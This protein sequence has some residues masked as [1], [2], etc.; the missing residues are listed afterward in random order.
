[1]AEDKTRGERVR[2]F[3]LEN[4]NDQMLFSEGLDDALIG[5]AE[6][7][8][9]PTLAVYDATK[10][11]DIFTKLDDA[12]VEKAAQFIE[13]TNYKV[14]RG[15]HSPLWFT[16]IRMLTDAT[17]AE[18]VKRALAKEN[19]S[20]LFADGLEAAIIGVAEREGQPTL[21][22]FDSSK[23]VD[24]FMERDKMDYEGACEFF[25]FNVSGGW[26]GEHTPLWFTALSAIT[27]LEDEV[28]EEE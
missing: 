21:A 22:V 28:G 14:W 16:P 23:C 20:M 17:K 18:A 13:L 2:K 24:I 10:A 12:N 6:R 5:I 1:M 15:E 3:L 27:E 7:C 8:S 19:P 9:Q 25:D 4:F 26:H 11:I